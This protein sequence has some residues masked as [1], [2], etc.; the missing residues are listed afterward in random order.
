LAAGLR[1]E[2]APMVTPALSFTGSPIVKPP[3]VALALAPAAAAASA[4]PLSADGVVVALAGALSEEEA[5][6]AVDGA[7]VWAAA[8]LAASTDRPAARGRNVERMEVS[9]LSLLGPSEA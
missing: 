8:T 9:L 3:A 6:G 2:I 1:A 5:G 4:E 7:G